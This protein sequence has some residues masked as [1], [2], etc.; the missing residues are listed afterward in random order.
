MGCIIA[1]STSSLVSPIIKP[2]RSVY[3][4]KF[5]NSSN[6]LECFEKMGGKSNF[7]WDEIEYGYK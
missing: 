6:Q 3:L 7:A 2:N 1:T 5:L 4:F